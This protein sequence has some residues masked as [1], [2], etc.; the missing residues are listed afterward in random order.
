MIKI[1][2]TILFSLVVVFSKAQTRPAIFT[3]ID[4]R[5]RTIGATTLKELVTKLTSPYKTE[6]EKVRSIFRWVTENISYDIYGYQ[7]IDS[8]YTGFWQPDYLKDD[9]IIKRDYNERIVNKVFKE[10]KAICDGYS[11]LFKSLCDE[12]NIKCEIITGIIRWQSDPI[13]VATKRE[14]AWNA[15]LINNDWKLI[16]ATWAIGYANHGVTKFTKL[17]ND[18]FFFPNP[19]KEVP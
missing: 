6:T 10:K 2:C 14:H 8:I 7:N 19:M 17:Y 5:A 3:S 13:G 12:A 18:F 4:K 1:L 15:V 11:R 16:D 9:S